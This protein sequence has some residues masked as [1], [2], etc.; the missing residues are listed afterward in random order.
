MLMW[1]WGAGLPDPLEYDPHGLLPIDAEAAAMEFFVPP[2]RQSACNE[3]PY[4]VAEHLYPMM[5][6]Q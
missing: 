1:L 2:L 5:A 3:G 6:F 4:S